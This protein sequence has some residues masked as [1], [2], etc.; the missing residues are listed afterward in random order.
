MHFFDYL[1]VIKSVLEPTKS[2][3]KQSENHAA[4]NVSCSIP[5]LWKKEPSEGDF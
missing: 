5:I 2:V 1:L 4:E 3:E